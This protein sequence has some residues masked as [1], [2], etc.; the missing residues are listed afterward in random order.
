MT[1]TLRWF[2]HRYDAPAWEDMPEATEPVYGIKCPMCG[3]EVERGNDGITIPDAITGKRSPMHLA[4]FLGNLGIEIW[5]RR[6][7]ERKE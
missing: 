2:G 7:E 5:P 6:L 3:A 4:C 1:G